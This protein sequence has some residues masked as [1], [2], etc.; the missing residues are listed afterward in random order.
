MKNFK[1][2]YDY[3]LLGDLDEENFL[4]N[5]RYHIRVEKKDD[6]SKEKQLFAL[7]MH[8]YP[9]IRKFSLKTQD[10]LAR[11][12]FDAYVKVAHLVS[13]KNK[14]LLK[15]RS[16]CVYYSEERWKERV[17][18]ARTR[19]VSD[20][21]LAIYMM[22]ITFNDVLLSFDQKQ[23]EFKDIVVKFPNAFYEKDSF[24]V[25][26][27]ILEK[28]D[29]KLSVLDYKQ[30]REWFSAMCSVFGPQNGDLFIEEMYHNSQKEKIIRFLETEY[31]HTIGIGKSLAG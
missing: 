26:P 19:E 25:S 30:M 24:Q 22:P 18:N 11:K 23:K 14:V 28:I 29:S 20:A 9:V 21:S 15:H 6:F 16:W 13:E 1:K 4:H 3:A 27:E 31:R 5:V 12:L 8:V 10:L 2:V 7:A 17:E